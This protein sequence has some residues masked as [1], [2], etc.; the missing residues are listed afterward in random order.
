MKHFRKK[1]NQYIW[2][3]TRS[4]QKLSISILGNLHGWIKITSESILLPTKGQEC[5]YLLLSCGKVQRKALFSMP[6]DQTMLCINT[7]K[8]NSSRQNDNCCMPREQNSKSLACVNFYR[9]INTK[10]QNIYTINNTIGYQ[11][12]E[13]TRLLHP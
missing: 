7:I 3:Q 10:T 12:Y 8:S 11:L 6:S 2:C 1:H 4:L 9:H 5:L 13:L